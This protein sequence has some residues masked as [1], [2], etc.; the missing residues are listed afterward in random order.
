[1]LK[2]LL[3]LVLLLGIVHTASAELA[4][5]EPGKVETLP[6]PYPDDWVIAHDIAFDHMSLGRFMVMDI[7]GEKVTDFFKGSFKRRQYCG[8]Y[9]GHKKARDVR[10]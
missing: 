1:M 5:D 7:T 8:L 6:V 3:R 4:R 10:A 2:Q 9:P